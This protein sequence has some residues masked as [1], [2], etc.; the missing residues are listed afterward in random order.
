MS[1]VQSYQS[2]FNLLM[3]AFGISGKELADLLH[4]DS[5]LVSKWKNSK[6]SLKEN[7]MHLNNIVQHFVSLDSLSGYSTIKSLLGQ[8]FE[9]LDLNSPVELSLA[10]KRWLLESTDTSADDAALYNFMHN[11]KHGRE[12]PCLQ[13][14]GNEGKRDAVLRLLKTAALL[15]PGQ[16]IWGLMW[17][18]QNWFTENDDYQQIWEQAN[19]EYLQRGNTIKII[20][21]NDRQYKSL[22]ESLLRWI[23]LYLTGRVTPY[24]APNVDGYDVKHVALLLK[25]KL[26][27]YGLSVDEASPDATVLAFT[28]PSIL[29]EAYRI[30]QR[31]FRYASPIFE[32]YFLKDY[33]KYAKFLSKMVNL[34]EQQYV[35]MRFPFVNVLSMEEI[36]DILDSNGITSDTK[37]VA[38]GAYR[39]LKRDAKKNSGNFFRYLIPQKQIESLLTKRKIMLDTPSFFSGKPL[40]ISNDAFR[41]LLRKLSDLLPSE[42]TYEMAL[43]ED[44]Y[45]GPP[46]T[47]NMF[48]KK[49][50]C[51]SVFN[52]PDHCDSLL[53]RDSFLLT[54]CESSVIL[55]LFRF[56]DK[57][58]YNTLTQRRDRNYVSRQL[59]ILTETIFPDDS[60]PSCE[61]EAGQPGD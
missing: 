61:H 27:L 41:R 22:A 59:R 53:L 35:L 31:T 52:S 10:L 28:S 57:L 30:L 25:D 23:P 17:D 13:F 48:V 38:L 37:E 26:L 58:W 18:T 9:N 55:S 11:S 49:D 36:E 45:V 34:D 40:Y 15:Q 46:A 1:T 32:K 20:H 24:Y 3:S 4:I 2:H 39:S 51:I 33:Y 50:T 7:S 43:L 42:S 54:T 14:R 29:N 12:C 56:C 44:G 19:L 16:E 8:D 5:S 47:L 21:A 60:A 6:R